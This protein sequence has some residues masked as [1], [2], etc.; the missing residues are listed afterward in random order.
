MENINPKALAIC[1]GIVFTIKEDRSALYLHN[2][3]H[4]G[5]MKENNLILKP[6]ET[7]YLVLLDRIKPINPFYGNIKKLVAELI[8]ENDMAGMKAY[9]EIKKEGAKVSI[10]RDFFSIARKQEKNKVARKVYPIM[11][12]S[13]VDTA[14]FSALADSFV[15]SVDEDGDI[16]YYSITQ[17]PMSG[18]NENQFTN[19]SLEKIGSR[20]LSSP[21][22]IP[23][24]M[25]YNLGGIKALSY[26]E[27]LL[28]EGNHSEEPAFKV[29]LYLVQHG[30]IV[31]SGFKYGCNFRAYTESINSHS[32]FLVQVFPN[33]MEWYEV[34]RAVRV[35]NS[36]RKDMIFP[37]QENG[38][39]KFIKVKRVRSIFFN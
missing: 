31:K 28:I 39:L 32:D 35:A 25:G 21:D 37:I 19:I 7:I 3:Y 27:T 17:V 29:Y 30:L 1:N 13:V 9:V 38:E 24:W 10:E 26:H 2:K 23:N 33:Q 22:G 36:V 34:S 11:E 4:I 18:K 12:N 14:W 5:T 8:S 15:A 16:T 6:Y 20:A